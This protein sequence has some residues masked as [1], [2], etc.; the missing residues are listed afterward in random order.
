MIVPDYKTNNN[1]EKYLIDPIYTNKI[2][3]FYFNF[4][5]FFF[6]YFVYNKII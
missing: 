2:I 4:T 5:L 6:V 1:E 3:Y